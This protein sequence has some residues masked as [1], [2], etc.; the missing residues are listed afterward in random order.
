MTMPNTTERD[1]EAQRA[2]WAVGWFLTLLKGRRAKDDLEVERGASGLD[3]LGIRVLFDED[4]E[5]R[6]TRSL[7]RGGK[8]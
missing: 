2:A 4:L 8:R 6:R 1:H 7:K 3:A 5:T